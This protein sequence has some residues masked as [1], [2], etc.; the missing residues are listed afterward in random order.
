MK[1]L[2]L[3]NGQKNSRNFSSKYMQVKFLPGQASRVVFLQIRDKSFRL[4]LDD[5]PEQ[6]GFDSIQAKCEFNKIN[7]FKHKRI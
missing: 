7:T 3:K 5:D 1:I 6:H 4:V 2:Q